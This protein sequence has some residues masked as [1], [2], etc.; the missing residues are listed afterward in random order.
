LLADQCNAV[1]AHTRLSPELAMLVVAIRMLRS[2]TPSELHRLGLSD[3]ELTAG[4]AELV[5]RGLIRWIDRPASRQTL[6]DPERFAV[7]TT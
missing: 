6:D 1:S 7:A 5:R 3:V 2:A 4:L